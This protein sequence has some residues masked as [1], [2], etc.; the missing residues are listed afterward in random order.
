MVDPVKIAVIP[1]LE[2]SRSVKQLCTTLGH[3][4]YYRKFIK[5][6]AHITMPMEKLLKKDVTFC[7][8]DDCKKILDILKEKMVTVLI[9]VFWDWKKEFHVHVD[10][11]CMAL[12]EVL[13]QLGQL[14]V[15][16]Y[17]LS[18]IEIGEEP[19]NLEEELPD[20]QLFVVCV[21]DGH[22][23]DIIHILMIVTS[24]EGY[25]IQQK[26]ELVVCALDFSVIAGH[27][28]KMGTN[29]ILRQYVPEFKRSSILVD[30]HGGAMGGHYL[31]TAIT[32][33][34]LQAGLW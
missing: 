15:G 19:T 18:R 25:T 20:M 1:N 34:T 5:G 32:Q 28:Y 24:P 9:L 2:A 29:E 8:N 6:Y 26:N 23:E 3:T 10:A 21:V 13:T 33:K 4:R 11:S 31:G 27:P 17:H 14:N 12:G 16:P 30:T 7:W 22:F